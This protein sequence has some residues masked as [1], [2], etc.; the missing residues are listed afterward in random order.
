MNSIKFVDNSTKIS[1]QPSS[2]HQESL[3]DLK[4]IIKLVI[5]ED[6]GLTIPNTPYLVKKYKTNI[7]VHTKVNNWMNQYIKKITTQFMYRT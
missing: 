7:I 5:D 2:Y 6:N 4:N 3:N 1:N